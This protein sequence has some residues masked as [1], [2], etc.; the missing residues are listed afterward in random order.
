M[1]WL[2]VH[3]VEDL[4]QGAGVEKRI[5]SQGDFT[6]ADLEHHPPRDD[7]VEALAGPLGAHRPDDPCEETT[8]RLPGGLGENLLLGLKVV[9]D[10]RRLDPNRSGK[11]PHRARMKSTVREQ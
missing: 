3:G 9:V 1:D 6:L 7:A 4:A 8:Q 5:V 10:R 11:I 2:P